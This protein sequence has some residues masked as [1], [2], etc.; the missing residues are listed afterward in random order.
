MA[1][2]AEAQGGLS[3]REA[4]TLDQEAPPRAVQTVL[5]STRIAGAA[6][7]K[8]ARTQRP[9]YHASIS[10]EAATPLRAEQITQ[11]VDHLEDRLGLQGQPRVVLLHRKKDREHIHVVWSRIEADTGNAVSYSWNYRLHEQAS[12]ELEAMFGHRPV[13]NSP[14][15]RVR[16]P[17]DAEDYE[18][19]QAER[20]GLSPSKASQEITA[21]W[22][23]AS[24]N[25]DELRTRL[26]ETG[27]TLARGDRRVFVVID[28]HGDS[29]L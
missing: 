15:R 29:N 16:A 17:G 19:R 1:A 12:R 9:L 5:R 26:A 2:E 23:A 24:A 3:D 10:P 4:Q 20:C 21:I 13:P 28:R 18:L 27:Y 14:A 8:A 11:A 22:N 7:A 6:R 25:P